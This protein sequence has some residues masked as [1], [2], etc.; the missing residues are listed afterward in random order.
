MYT[1]Q[2]ILEYQQYSGTDKPILTEGKAIRNIEH[3]L[4]KSWVREFPRGDDYPDSYQ[5]ILDRPARLWGI[6]YL[7]YLSSYL[8]QY[9]LADE[10]YRVLEREY[11]K[12]GTLL[13]RPDLDD[14]NFYPR[15]A[16]HA[17]M[18]LSYYGWR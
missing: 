13:F 15:H 9:N 4:E 17:L 5:A 1:L 3:F 6:G 14:R 2:G 8:R 7:L 18:G 11:L 10:I 16:A 12:H